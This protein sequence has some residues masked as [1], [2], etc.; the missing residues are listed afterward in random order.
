MPDI[1]NNGAI[2]YTKN[3]GA[4]QD[5]NKRRNIN[6][7][8]VEEQ[9]GIVVLENSSQVNLDDNINRVNINPKNRGDSTN[10]TG[11]CIKNNTTSCINNS[12]GDGNNYIINNHVNIANNHKDSST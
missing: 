11:G 12:M 3:N 4:L 10:N 7:G 8:V 6:N 9:S 2:D 1:K 5:I